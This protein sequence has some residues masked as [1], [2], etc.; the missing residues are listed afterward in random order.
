MDLV[1][2]ARAW[3]SASTDTSFSFGSV[4][5]TTPLTEQASSRTYY[6]PPKKKKDTS[7]ELLWKRWMIIWVASL[8]RFSRRNEQ[9]AYTTRTFPIVKYRNSP[10]KN[11]QTGKPFISNTIRTARYTFWDFL[12]RQLV[13]QFSKLANFY[14]LFVA[15]IQLV[16]SWSPTGRYTTL[17]PLAIFTSIAMAHEGY[18]DWRRSVADKQENAKTAKV[19]R[20]YHSHADAETIES[21]KRAKPWLNRIWNRPT[22]SE[23]LDYAMNDNSKSNHVCVWQSVKWSDLQVGDYVMVEKNQWIPA[24]LILLHSPEEQGLCYLETAALDGETNHKS[25]QAT[26]YTNSLLRTPEDLAAFE[27]TV[28]TEMPDPNLYQFDGYLQLP[29]RQTQI[30]TSYPLTINNVL[31]RGTLLRNTAFVYGLVAFTGEETKIRLNSTMSH[32]KSPRIQHAINR[33]I[34]A[35]FV[36]LV[37]L[38]A[39]FSALSITWNKRNLAGAWYLHESHQDETG[40]VFQFII[41]FNTLIPI[42]LYVTMEIV[43]LLQA[44]Y[45]SWDRDMYHAETDTPAQAQTCTINEDLGQ[46]SFVFSDK[47]GTLTDNV[48][49]FRKCSVGGFSYT[50]DPAEI[51]ASLEQPQPQPT[52]KRNGHSRE[53]S[54]TDLESNRLSRIIRH[55]G[56]LSTLSLARRVHGLKPRQSLNTHTLRDRFF[57]IALAVCHTAVPEMNDDNS[58]TYQAASP[59]EAALVSAARELGFTVIE[60]TLRS[61]TL[62]IN[63]ED[64]PMIVEILNIIE[65]TSDRKR[66]SIVI[67]LPTDEIILIC[68]G[69]DSVILERMDIPAETPARSEDAWAIE[70]VPQSPISPHH[71]EG[72]D[73]LRDTRWEFARTMEHLQDYATDGLRT[74]L[75]AYRVLSPAQ[76]DEWNELYQEACLAVSERQKKVSKTAEL[77]ECKLRLI[78]ASA[79]EDKLQEGV[80]EAIECIRAAGMRIWML[81][82]DKRE[83]AIN[84]GYSCR[85]IHS[86]SNLIVLGEQKDLRSYMEQAILDLQNNVASHAAFV[87]DGATLEV[88]AQEEDLLELFCHLGCLSST[89][90]CCRVSPSQKALVVKS[91]RRSAPRAV[92]L[93]IGDGANDIAMIQEAHV[94]IGITGKEGMQA[95][96]ASDYCFAQ[97]RFLCKLLLVHGHWSYVRVSRFVLGTFAKVVTFYLTQGVYQFWTGFSGTSLYESWT[98]SMYNTLFSSLPVISVGIFEQDLNAKTLLANPH[99]YI[100]GQLNQA[101]DLRIFITWVTTSVYQAIVVVVVPIAL[102]SGLHDKTNGGF[103]LEGAPQIYTLGCII[104]TIIVIVVTLVISYVENHN[105]T[106]ISHLFAWIELIGFFVYQIIYGYAYPVGNSRQYDVHGDFIR[107]AGQPTFWLLVILVT[108]VALL[109][110]IALKVLKNTVLPNV[111]A[112]FQQ[113]EKDPEVSAQWDEIASKWEYEEPSDGNVT[114]PIVESQP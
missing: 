16:P 48:M 109:P 70:S 31:L 61:I 4:A 87:V 12:P 102:I 11:A 47:T 19:L 38:S 111:T 36:F 14:F 21:S 92:T 83:T 78:G 40:T 54:K 28:V 101:F 100:Q 50:H 56:E 82:G 72:L 33:A 39:L 65:F 44:L 49:E 98:L 46:I 107:I 80:P 22:R 30:K 52:R 88:L 29:T 23:N 9:A 7:L 60:R 94:G 8:K 51:Q 106:W 103:L 104:Y 26:P 10:L 99:L 110:S 113:A 86:N 96:R 84:I 67:K 105:Q 35:M 69:A 43:K 1:R 62:K 63:G 45:I 93:A 42:S 32:T 75:Y 20:V 79:I 64:D 97:F 112:A 24:D 27:G 77:I 17:L 41:L 55:D 85:L 108:T 2:R 53:Q 18:D 5:S 66:M 90:I 15:A 34:I 81:T 76:Y 25:R 37:A 74:L 114:S 68:K 13:A 95:S 91:I 6:E 57:M 73:G 58:I 3:S 59:D 71:N 89:V